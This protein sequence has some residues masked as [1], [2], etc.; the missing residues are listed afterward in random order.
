MRRKHTLSD[1][2]CVEL[3]NVK[4]WNGEKFE[5]R[6][7]VY[8][9]FANRKF[10]FCNKEDL[11]DLT[12]KVV[13]CNGAL[14]M[15]ALFGLGLDFMEPLRD[16]VYTFN[17]GLDAMHRGGFFGGLYENAANPIDDCEKLSAANDR[18]VKDSFYSAL[19]I[20]FLGA[21]SKD[22][23]DKLGDKTIT[24]ENDSI[25]DNV[26]LYATD[27]DYYSCASSV[28]RQIDV[29]MNDGIIAHKMKYIDN[30]IIAIVLGLFVNFFLIFA[31][32]RNSNKKEHPSLRVAHLM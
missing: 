30:A 28:F 5:A 6:D 8:A 29:V 2:N 13:D 4:F 12:V 16:D 18:L 3:K 14:V 9:G 21:F 31:T 22:F 20:K 26:Y 19:A 7:S 1:F 17:D 24:K 27:G 25:V 32:S 11:A 10:A 15:P 23:G